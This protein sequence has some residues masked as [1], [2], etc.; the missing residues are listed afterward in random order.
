MAPKETELI[1][2]GKRRGGL[3]LACGSLLLAVGC[4]G[5]GLDVDYDY[6]PGADFSKLR[7][8]GWLPRNPES[9]EQQLRVKRIQSAVTAQLEARGLKA[10]ETPDFLIGMQVSGRTTEK[11]SVGV[12]ASVGVPVGRGTVT[13]GGGRRRSIEET[14]GTLVLDFVSPAE[15][16]LLWHGSATGTVDPKAT[17]EQQEQRISHA[18][19]EMLKN[20]PPPKG[21]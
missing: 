17:P 1:Q 21:K 6:D 5:K 14:E 13:L 11:G 20:F 4:G 9:G 18:V 12:G 7:S 19:G 15:K 2:A 8:F 10:S 3:L 16:S